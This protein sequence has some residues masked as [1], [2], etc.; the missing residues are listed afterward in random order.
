[1]SSLEPIAVDDRDDVVCV[2]HERGLWRGEVVVR[3]EP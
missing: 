2:R 1:M 3:V